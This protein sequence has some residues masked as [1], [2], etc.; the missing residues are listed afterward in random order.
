V[1]WVSDDE[2]LN[3][4][5]GLICERGA[6][7]DITQQEDLREIQ[8]IVKCYRRRRREKRRTKAKQDGT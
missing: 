4:R 6:E 3:D 8:M 5:R 1:L 2:A 7:G